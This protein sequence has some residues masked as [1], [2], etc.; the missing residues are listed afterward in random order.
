MTDFHTRPYAPGDATAVAE[1]INLL[2]AA[3]GGHA[4]HV[5]SEIEDLVHHEVRD[6]AADTRVVIDA[7]GRLA[8]VAFVPLPPDGG[9]RLELVGGVHPDRRGA[10]L[11]RQLLAWQLERAAARHA[12]LAPGATWHAQVIAGDADAAPIRLYERSGFTVARYFLEMSAPTT[13]APVAEPPAGLRLAPY[14]PALERAV[15]AAHTAAFRD[16]WGYQERTFDAWAPLTVRSSAFL[17]ALSRLALA[18][19]EIAGYALVYASE[20]PGRLY[21]G[22]V[23]T[24][25][26]RRRAGIASALLAGMLGAAG[27]AGYTTAGLDTDAANPTGAAGVYAKVGFTVDHRVV[28]YRRPIGTGSEVSETCGS[29]SAPAESDGTDGVRRRRR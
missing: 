7:D 15:H 16:L 25:P 17:P 2:S 24:A 29:P 6:V 4:A 27:R 19:S 21:V 10:G 22:Q 20:T 3:G 11:G 14:D 5:A 12:E 28:A 8:A 23:G 26:H 9:D 18:G 13:P 1:L